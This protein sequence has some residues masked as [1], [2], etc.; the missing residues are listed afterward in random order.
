MFCYLFSSSCLLRGPTGGTVWQKQERRPRVR[1]TGRTLGAPRTPTYGHYDP[2][3]GSLLDY[4]SAADRIGKRGPRC[5]G[6]GLTK[7][8]WWSAERRGSPIARAPNTPRRRMQGRS[9]PALRGLA[10][11]CAFRR[12]APLARGEQRG[13]HFAN[14]GRPTPRKRETAP[15]STRGV[16]DRRRHTMGWVR[17]QPIPI[18]RSNR[19]PGV[20]RASSRA[21]SASSATCSSSGDSA[22]NRM[23]APS[24]LRRRSVRLLPAAPRRDAARSRELAAGR[25]PVGDQGYRHRRAG[26]PRLR[27]VDAGQEPAGTPAARPNHAKPH[28]RLPERDQFSLRSTRHW[29]WCRGARKTE[30]SGPPRGRSP[31]EAVAGN[32]CRPEK[33]APH[34]CGGQRPAATSPP[35][36]VA[37][38][39]GRHTVVAPKSDSRTSVEALQRTSQQRHGLQRRDGEAPCARQ[40]RIDPRC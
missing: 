39:Q 40:V 37:S 21:A 4:R 33:E 3:A 20:A 12:S 35:V 26:A 6:P 23:P 10:N 8:P 7:T 36:S 5:V 11:P 15:A 29:M 1:L 19:R 32:H 18:V 34:A 30:R 2:C 31:V 17:L 13:R 38:G 14:P 16:S 22:A 25:R 9:H 27:P 24:W 28:A